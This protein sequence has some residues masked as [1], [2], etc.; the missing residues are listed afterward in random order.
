M[1]TYDFRCPEGHEF[2]KSYRKISDGVLELPCPE[3]GKIAL[4]KVSGGAG[5]HFKGSGF[6]L[7]DYGKNAHRK[8][9]APASDSSGAAGETKGGENTGSD[10]S[11]SDSAA[12][13][14]AESKK[15]ADAAAS[16]KPTAKKRDGAAKKSDN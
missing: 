2:E 3:C 15:T 11:A 4:R 13:K 9:A 16:E 6:Y 5:L 7:T 14:P 1:P 12:A 10:G 8:A